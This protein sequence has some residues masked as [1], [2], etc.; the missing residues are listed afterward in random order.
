MCDNHRTQP[1]SPAP[2]GDHSVAH[3]PSVLAYIREQLQQKA[4]QLSIRTFTMMDWRA[5]PSNF[6]QQYLVTT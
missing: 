6:S 1:E 4:H 2:S 5:R 3:E